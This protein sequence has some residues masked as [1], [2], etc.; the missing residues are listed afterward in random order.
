MKIHQYQRPQLSEDQRIRRN[1]EVEIHLRPLVLR[2]LIAGVMI[3]IIVGTLM[4]YVW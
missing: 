2:W 1:D 4:E 3:A